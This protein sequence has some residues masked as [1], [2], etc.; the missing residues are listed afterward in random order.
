MSAAQHRAYR[1]TVDDLLSFMN[2]GAA[3]GHEE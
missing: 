1:P 3:Q 2:G